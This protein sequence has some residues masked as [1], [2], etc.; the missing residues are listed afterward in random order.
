MFVIQCFLFNW[1]EF[2]NHF[3]TL[4]IVVTLK[5]PMD[6]KNKLKKRTI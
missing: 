2:T 3:G 4:N 1:V 5:E 6:K